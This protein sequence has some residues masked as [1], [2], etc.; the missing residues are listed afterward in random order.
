MSLNSLASTTFSTGPD[1]KTIVADIYT[2]TEPGVINSIDDNFNALD[3]LLA[4]DFKVT[5]LTGGDLD[6][7]FNKKLLDKALTESS[8]AGR[9]STAVTGIASSYRGLS[10][11][12]KKTLS[13]SPILGRV[14]N[15]TLGSAASK[16]LS[17]NLGDAK[18]VAGLIDNFTKGGYQVDFT[19]KGAITGL[20]SGIVQEGSRLGLPNT[21]TKIAT[22]INNKGIMM[23]A[24][25]TLLPNIA[26]S[27]NID[28]L[29]DIANSSI[30]N[31]IIKIM[32]NVIPQ[33]LGN[34]SIAPTV[35]KKD[36]AAQYDYIKETFDDINS[37][38][39]TIK[40]NGVS[41]LSGVSVSKFTGY[42][43]LLNAKVVKQI[44]GVVVNNF[45]T[46]NPHIEDEKFLLVARDSVTTVNSC[47]KSAFPTVPVLTDI[48]T[49]GYNVNSPEY[50]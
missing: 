37:G 43:D 16:I 9:I 36:Y 39:N 5:D 3:K 17:K 28:L 29:R 35:K 26:T 22:S 8:I 45:T 20:I 31:E 44:H 50:A 23:A 6:A 18:A 32:P 27:G 15:A 14:V 21:F 10:D 19:D 11:A 48:V 42:S 34:Y 2:I 41:T 24:A 13:I 46:V 38:W 30:G 40:R 33:T 49:T 47:L 4:R 25:S 12:V 7:V 1:D